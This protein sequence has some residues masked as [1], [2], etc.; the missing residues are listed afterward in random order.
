[1]L[2]EFPV[3]Q[4]DFVLPRWVTML[5]ADHWLQQQIYQ[6]VQQWAAEVCQMKD[7]ARGPG[8]ECESLAGCELD[9]LDLATGAVRMRMELRE[10]I[11]YQVLGE[12][13]GLEVCD[14]A[15]LMPCVIQLAKTS[16]VKGRSSARRTTA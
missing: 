13:T 2:Y 10:G 15:S 12:Q 6:A 16:G 8:V 4:V 1:M 9:A 3:R 5:D 11:F 7:A 14:E